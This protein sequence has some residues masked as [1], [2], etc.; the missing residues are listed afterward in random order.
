MSTTSSINVEDI[1]S[2]ALAPKD[3]APKAPT[4][5]MGKDDFL[6]LLTNQMKN[7]DPMNPTDN[8]QMMAQ[9]AQF[10]SLEQMQN[11]NQSFEAYRGIGMI[12]KLVQG[13]D[14]TTNTDFSGQV[15]AA[16]TQNGNTTLTLSTPDKQLVTVTIGD[17]GLVTN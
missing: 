11:L 3:A 8:T 4:N 14:H 13:V 12:G 6:A 16:H 9:L 17:I 1:I 5:Q 15:V 2:G 10:S 7:Q